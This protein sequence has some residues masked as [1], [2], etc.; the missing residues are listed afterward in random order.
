MT[1]Q[2]KNLSE[3][4]AVLNEIRTQN[5][6]GVAI[7]AGATVEHALRLAIEARGENRPLNRF[8]RKIEV[9][10]A[11]GFVDKQTRDYLNTVRDI[12][13]E[14]AHDMMPLTFT[15]ETILKLCNN[16]PDPDFLAGGAKLV[17]PTDINERM[18]NRVIEKAWDLMLLLIG[19][20]E[21]DDTLP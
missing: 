7:T 3:F 4:K 13:N 12:R 15:S 5:D 18:R 14:F 10:Y 16:L 17:P 8:W 20:L 1:H 21:I 6:R 2:W 19:D 9:A 11:R